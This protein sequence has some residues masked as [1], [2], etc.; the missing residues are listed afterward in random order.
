M[1]D[2]EVPFPQRDLHV[3]DEADKVR[4][5]WPLRPNQSDGPPGG[6]SLQSPAPSQA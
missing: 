3:R 1:E 2:I 4:I 6:D 5:N